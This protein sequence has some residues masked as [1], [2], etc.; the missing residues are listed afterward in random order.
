[1]RWLRR[2]A[3]VIAGI[4]AA[5]FLFGLTRPES[6]VASTRARYASAPDVVW[7]TISDVES[8]P[9]WNPEVRSVE[10]MPE[11]NGRPAVN[12]VGSWGEAPTELTVIEPPT[13]MRT[14]MD[15]GDFSGSWT[16]EL[17]PAPE[18]GTLLTVT[19]EGR[20]GSPLFR[21]LMIF[22]DNYATMM[23]FHRALGARLG[24]VV[25]AERVEEPNPGGGPGTL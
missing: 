2:G 20:V 18:G 17:A 19:E 24:E 12:I 23:E 22:H 3:L 9:E 16:Y 10:R 6:H 4:F 11:R 21:A 5:L 15:A 1:V 13:R 8:W 25:A 14:E 7:S